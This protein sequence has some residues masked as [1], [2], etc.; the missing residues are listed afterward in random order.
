[1]LKRISIKGAGIGVIVVSSL[2]II[3]ELLIILRVLPF[4]IIGGG[5]LENYQEAMQTATLSIVILVIN[6]IITLIGSG[7]IEF[8]RFKKVI[9][10]WLWI[11]FSYM[12]IN[13]VLNLLGITLFEK[14]VMTLV[15]LIQAILLLR[16]A[17]YK[18]NVN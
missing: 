2:V 11:F 5:R 18:S 1:M 7:I 15:S 17:A 13:I 14:I 8:N 4:D 3:I 16:I 6:C 10:V 12:C 9:R